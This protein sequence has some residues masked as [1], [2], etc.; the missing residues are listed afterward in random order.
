MV[1]LVTE[2]MAGDMAGTL[3][4]GMWVVWGM[5][6]VVGMWAAAFMSVARGISVEH[7]QGSL[8]AV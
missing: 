3:V 4:A 2:V 1:V 7:I 5:S 6:V 8:R